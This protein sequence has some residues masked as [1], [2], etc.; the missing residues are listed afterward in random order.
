MIPGQPEDIEDDSR[1]LPNLYAAAER[2]GEYIAAN[3]DGIYDVIGGHP[4]YARDLEA[5]RQAANDV[6]QLREM[7]LNER[8]G[9]PARTRDR[10]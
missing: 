4:L 9:L 8:E 7:L 1:D 2:V 5:L 10:A 3:G 6:E